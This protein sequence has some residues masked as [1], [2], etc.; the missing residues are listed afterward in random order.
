[1]CYR[2]NSILCWLS[3]D[4]NRAEARGN[5]DRLCV[6]AVLLLALRRQTGNDSAKSDYVTVMLEPGGRKGG[7]RPHSM[8]Q[9][10]LRN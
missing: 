2:R 8:N 5:A 3:C 1:M 4:Y 6:K 9:T 10:R 7:H